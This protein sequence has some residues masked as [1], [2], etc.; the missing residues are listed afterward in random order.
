MLKAK[1]QWSQRKLYYW[2]LGLKFWLHNV[3]DL[4]EPAV[5][6]LGK[7]HISLHR[8]HLPI[9]LILNIWEF[10][11]GFLNCIFPYLC[12]KCEKDFV[13]KLM[14]MTWSKINTA[15]CT[16]K[17]VWS[18]NYHCSVYR[19]SISMS[20]NTGPSMVETLCLRLVFMMCVIIK[21]VWHE[22]R[23]SQPRSRHEC[24]FSAQRQG[25][26][27][28]PHSYVSK[29]PPRKVKRPKSGGWVASFS[30]YLTLPECAF[31][32]LGDR[33]PGSFPEGSYLCPSFKDGTEIV[34]SS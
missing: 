14:G 24:R 5:T 2:F 20:Y 10:Y 4:P 33:A 16:R 21:L 25:S 19:E 32:L 22:R 29:T 15:V 12:D 6:I 8:K 26:F 23:M 27:Q 1:V 17:A 28:S 31:F 30:P 13:V 34:P 3:C 18:I 9:C 7:L 11:L